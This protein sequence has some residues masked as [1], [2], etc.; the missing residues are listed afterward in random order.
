MFTSEEQLFGDESVVLGNDALALHC[1]DRFI[2][3][4][5]TT[6]VEVAMRLPDVSDAEKTSP[7]TGIDFDDL[8]VPI[9]VTVR[10]E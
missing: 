2:T 6:V 5:C 10:P 1:C 3:R 8:T 9:A 4:S 7:A